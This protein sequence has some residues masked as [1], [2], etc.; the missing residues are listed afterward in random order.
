MENLA[1]SGDISVETGL[2]RALE[3]SLRDLGVVG[4][5]Y[6]R[7][8]VDQNVHDL[9]AIERRSQQIKDILLS[10]SLLGRDTSHQGTE[11]NEGLH[12]AGNEGTRK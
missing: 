2:L 5:G 3:V 10:S 9:S 4:E 12:V 6:S 1:L 11:K 7:L 8:S